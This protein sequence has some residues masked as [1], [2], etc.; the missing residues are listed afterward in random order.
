MALKTDYKDAMFDG[1]RR[2]RMIPNEDGTYCLPDETTYTQEGDK[3]GANDINAT[4]LEVNRLG[5][6]MAV[7]LPASGWSSSAP[8]SQ[9]VAVEGMKA[10]DVVRIYPYTPSTLSSATVKQYRKMAGMI[11]DGESTAG[12]MTF[13]CGVKKPTAD[14][15]VY[16]EGVSEDG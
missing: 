9:T 10:T 4:N 5:R 7:A 8:Y 2:Y 6:G 11:T 3:F 1:Q 16:L 12:A 13:Y 15:Q 14:F